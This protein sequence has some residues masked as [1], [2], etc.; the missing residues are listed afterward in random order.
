M[1]SIRHVVLVCSKTLAD[2]IQNDRV[3]PSSLSSQL[4]V[5]KRLIYLFLEDID[6]DEGIRI[7]AFCV[8]PTVHDEQHTITKQ[9]KLNT[10]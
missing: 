10:E 6:K 5:L 8:L 3:V 7:A 9:H 1:Y 2:W 4:S